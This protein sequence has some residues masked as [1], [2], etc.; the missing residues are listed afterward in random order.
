MTLLLKLSVYRPAV[1]LDLTIRLLMNAFILHRLIEDIVTNYVCFP[2]C[3]FQL[4]WVCQV[5]FVTPLIVHELCFLTW[6]WNF[7][8]TQWSNFVEFCVKRCTSIIMCSVWW[9]LCWTQRMMKD[10]LLCSLLHRTF[11]KKSH[12]IGFI[13][14]MCMLVSMW[15]WVIL[16][17]MDSN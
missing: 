4:V 1:Y 6:Q 10:T 9:E 12:F 2:N 15:I 7:W 5:W 13:F 11:H 17:T 16:C 8:M 14:Q 3:L